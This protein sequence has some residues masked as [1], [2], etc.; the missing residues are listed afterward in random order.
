MGTIPAYKEEEQKFTW[1]LGPYFTHR[2]FDPDLPLSVG[3]VQNC[4][5]GMN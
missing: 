4:V 1:S 5:Q 2:L 3:L